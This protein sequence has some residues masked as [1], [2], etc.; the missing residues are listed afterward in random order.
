MKQVRCTRGFG[1][2]T[3]P[4]SGTEYNV[5]RDN[6]VE[7]ADSVAERLQANYPGVVVSDVESEPVEENPTC[8][9]N[10]CSRE[11]DDPSDSCWQH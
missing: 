9:V 5:Q 3:D 7:V 4:E 1:V 11:V 8:G 10:G 6:T 2:I